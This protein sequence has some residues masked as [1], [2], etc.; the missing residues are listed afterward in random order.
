MR[1]VLYMLLAY[2]WLIQATWFLLNLALVSF[3]D[4][5]V[6]GVSAIQSGLNISGLDFI[7]R[8]IA[9]VGA[10]LIVLWADRHPLYKGASF[11]AF[12]ATTVITFSW[13]STSLGY[14]YSMFAT[15]EPTSMWNVYRG[16]GGIFDC[17]L[18][19]AIM[20]TLHFSAMGLIWA[21]TLYQ[22][23]RATSTVKLAMQERL[24]H[25]LVWL[26]LLSYITWTAASVALTTNLAYPQATAALAGFWQAPALHGLV[27]FAL[28]AAAVSSL[29]AD[30]AWRTGSF[31]L[32]TALFVSLFFAGVYMARTEVFGGVPSQ[33]GGFGSGS[34]LAQDAVTA[35]FLAVSAVALLIHLVSIPLVFT[36]TAPEYATGV[37]TVSNDPY[38]TSY[39]G[40]AQAAPLAGERPA[41]GDEHVYQNSVTQQA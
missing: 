19:G 16:T 37:K 10:T 4:T 38:A 33:C 36:R 22:N 32:N 26:G 2:A 24:L 28:T 9:T 7:Y 41:Y 11:G 5:Q 39:N 15:T 20:S 17:L 8:T 18:G 3:N 30:Q 21:Y 34:C 31:F 1:P 23:Y 35:G 29:G 6:N 12:I 25:G 14:A 40:G 27:A 13:L